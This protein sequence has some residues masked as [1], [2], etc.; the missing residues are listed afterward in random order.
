MSGR[1]ILFITKGERD[2]ATR[3]RS[4]AYFDRLRASG[5]D[6]VHMAAKATWRQ[7]RKLLA[8]AAAADVVVVQRKTFNPLF[9]H[10]LNSR[11]RRL[12]YDLD[13]AVFCRSDGTPS[14]TRA[15]R[16]ARIARH[17]S[18]IWAGNTY[19]AETSKRYNASVRVLP[20]SLAP[21]K[22]AVETQKP[23]GSIDLVWIGSRST[24]KYLEPAVKIFDGVA[25]R[26]PNLRLKIVADFDLAGH[27]LETAAIPWSESGEASALASAHIGVA[28]MPDNPWTRGK[29]ALKVIQ[30]MAAGLP[31]VSSPAGVNGEV[32][33]HGISG[34]LAESPEQWQ[35][36][37]LTLCRDE[38]LRGKMGRMGRKR[39][40]EDYSIQATFPK[41]LAALGDLCA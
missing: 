32:V 29:C 9:F 22:Y 28:P 5:W 25:A 2:S 41:M 7:R 16:F 3:Y 38:N 13:D 8:T 6:A 17:C 24:R 40:A 23:S 15:R 4:L 26:V 21:E 34:F 31:V 35:A 39:A 37:L 11:C 10:L 12:V 20:T 19:L 36:A 27:L 18:Q 33:E 30:Y 14:R 1:R